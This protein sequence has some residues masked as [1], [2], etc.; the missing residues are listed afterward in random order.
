MFVM[1]GKLSVD[2]SLINCT[3][4]WEHTLM[5]S[6]S[7]DALYDTHE[8]VV[9]VVGQNVC[10]P[11]IGWGSVADNSFNSSNKRRR[12]DSCVFINAVEAEHWPQSTDPMELGR[13]LIV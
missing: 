9:A 5:V 4:K 7:L 13:A 11:T 3:R 6:K 2:V 8:A 12:P 1:L 10:V